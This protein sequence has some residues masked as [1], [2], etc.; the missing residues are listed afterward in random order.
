MHWLVSQSL[1]LVRIQTFDADGNPEDGT[2]SSTPIIS[3]PGYSPKAIVASI[4]LGGIMLLSLV[5]LGYRRYKG[6]IPLVRNNSL[7]ISAACHPEDD[8][9]DPAHSKVMWGAVFHGDKLSPGHCCITS[10]RVT[11]PIDG[12]YYAGPRSKKTAKANIEL[13]QSKVVD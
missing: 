2:Q 7:A 1:F 3:A 12:M 5:A 6:G 9:F 4:A 10:K 13:I 11:P 8:D